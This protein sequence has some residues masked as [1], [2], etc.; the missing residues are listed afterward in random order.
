MRQ[1]KL[2]QFSLGFM[3]NFSHGARPGYFILWFSSKSE[4]EDGFSH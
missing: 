4:K 3:F 1:L 2:D